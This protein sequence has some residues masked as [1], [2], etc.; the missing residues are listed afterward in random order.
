MYYCVFYTVIMSFI[1]LSND[2]PGN[3]CCSCIRNL[4]TKGTKLSNTQ[5]N[6]SFQSSDFSAQLQTETQSG[7]LVVWT[8]S[9]ENSGI[10]KITTWN[11]DKNDHFFY[12]SDIRILFQCYSSPYLKNWNRSCTSLGAGFSAEN[13]GNGKGL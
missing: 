9:S 2:S 11:A 4:P 5:E 12:Q 6:F 10:Y 8:P 1:Q 3:T 7:L 13:K